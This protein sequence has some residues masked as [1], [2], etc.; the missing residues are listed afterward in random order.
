VI[1]VD[2]EWCESA[3]SMLR[4]MEREQRESRARGERPDSEFNGVM[5]GYPRRNRNRYEYSFEIDC[6]P[7]MRGCDAFLQIGALKASQRGL[8]LDINPSGLQPDALGRIS[9]LLQMLF[10]SMEVDRFVHLMR[11][12]TV[13]RIDVAA[14]IIGISP[15]G[16]LIQVPNKTITYGH[17]G[18]DGEVETIRCG[19]DNSRLSVQMYNKTLQ[20]QCR[21]VHTAARR[22][23]IEAKVKRQFTLGDIY[24]ISNPLAGV[25]VYSVLKAQR[26]LDLT[27]RELP[28]FIDS[29]I[30]RGIPGALQHLPSRRTRGRYLRALACAELSCWDTERLWSGFPE[31]VERVLTVLVPCLAPHGMAA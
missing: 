13:T 19:A 30:L 17:Y 27:D 23:R 21:G 31:C 20:L 4:D 25:M 5:L 2:N 16:L 18:P 26:E 24:S 6:N 9:W 29:C 11:N 8:R 15:K 28:W 7:E 12:A 3:I 22:T 10:A 14:D 1:D